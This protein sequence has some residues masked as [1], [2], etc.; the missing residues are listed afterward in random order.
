[1][2][3]CIREMNIKGFGIRGVQSPVDT[4]GQADPTIGVNK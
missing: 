1:M 3:F 2:S 4:E